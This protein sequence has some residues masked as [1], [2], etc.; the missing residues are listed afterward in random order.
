MKYLNL[1]LVFAPVAIVGALAGATPTL[2]FVASALAVI[3]AAGILGHATE[4]LAAHTGPRV[5]GLLNATLG[6]AA[7]LIITLFAIRAGLLDLVKASITG[8]IL[9]NVL[10][11]MGASVLAGGVRN[12]TQRFDRTHAGVNATQLLLAVLALMIPSLFFFAHTETAGP[13]ESLSLGTAVAMIIV[14]AL[15]L[16]FAFRY[17]SPEPALAQD[18]EAEHPGGWSVGKSVAVLLATTALIAWL[19][20][21]LVGSVEHTTQA[22]GLSEFF[23]GIIVV[24]LVGNVAEHVVAVQA[25]WR[26][27]MEL[28]MAV[29]VGSSLQIA[30]FVAPVLVFVSLLMGHPLTLVFNP[31]EIVALFAGVLI[32]AFVSQDGETNWLEGAQLLGVYAILALA[33]LFLPA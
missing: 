29:S 24:P 31:F 9:G 18:V 22:L 32:A 5:G 4:E 20:E 26:N 6:N 12:G 2:L 11:V 8:S 28:S 7:E 25:A 10:L 14:Y 13:V 15:G 17:A 19:S 1:L 33:F 23:I 27:K 21:I 16:L 30:L 3:P